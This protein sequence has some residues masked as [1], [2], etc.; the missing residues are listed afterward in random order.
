[1]GAELPSG[2]VTF[3]FTDIEG[4][5][6]LF[7][8]L[9]DSYP[10]LLERHNA[11][12]RDQ[13]N[14]HR[15]VE[16]K[17]E[18]DSF[19]VAFGSAADAFA[20]AVAAQRAVSM[21][22]WPSGA[23]VR[24]RIGIHTGAAYPRGNDYVALALH[25][26]ARVVGAAVGGQTLASA[27]AV[28]AAGRV[29]GVSVEP[30]GA[31]RL[32][33]FEGPAHLHQ[34]TGPGVGAPGAAVVRAV[35][36]DG[37][38]L[39]MP[40][41]S[42]VGREVELDD[43]RALLAPCRIVTIVAPGGMGKTRL[44]TEVGV[45]VA[46]AWGD[47]VW[48][49]ELAPLSDPQL[50]PV[51]IAHAV[52]VS[53]GGD[54]EWG[55]VIEH[56]RDRSALIILDN[57]EHLLAAAATAAQDLVTRCRG[58]GVLATSRELLGMRGEVVWRLPPLAVVTD[59]LTLFVNRARSTAPQ[60]DAAAFDETV[61]RDICAQLDG[62]PLAIELAA[63]RV[64]VLSLTEIRDGL[65]RRFNLLRTRDSTVPE[66]QRTMRGLLD[67]SVAL[68]ATHEKAALSRLAVFAGTFDVS[69]AA[70]AVAHSGIEVEDVDELVWSLADKSLVVVERAMGATRYRLLDTVRAYSTELLEKVEEADTTRLALARWFL[71]QYPFPGEG[72]PDRLAAL[73][74]ELES[75]VALIEPLLA[76]DHAEEAHFLAM[77]WADHQAHTR[78]HLRSTLALLRQVI[79]RSSRPTT[80]LARIHIFAS[81]LAGSTDE[82]NAARAHLREAD[83][84]V[85]LL[86][87]DDRWG[88]IPVSRGHARQ[89]RREG[90]PEALRRAVSLMEAE[91]AAAPDARDRADSMMLL[92][93]L[94]NEL[95]EDTGLA[96]LAEAVDAAREH[97][98]HGLLVAALSESAEMRLR[99]GDVRAAAGYQKQAL[100][101]GRE[102]GSEI[103]AAFS[104]IVAARI[105][106][107]RGDAVQ[108]V[109]LHGAADAILDE[110][111]FRLLPGDRALSDSMLDHARVTL[112]DE[113]F[114]R[115]TAAG[116]AMCIDDTIRL[117]DALLENAIDDLGGG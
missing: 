107:P 76:H 38:N 51:A 7:R 45:R 10:P 97:D 116:R 44:A 17:T 99:K 100:Q 75:V 37:H 19:L 82:A 49:V 46:P 8:R 40:L 94:L 102:L 26:A 115:Q 22:A 67:W 69:S 28:E 34:V 20:A 29:D 16:V 54:D 83:A 74:L 36:A 25:Q 55:A 87:G 15:G 48:M 59:S 78:G 50:V 77:L 63:A 57:C 43:I 81:A 24:V 89:A 61:V 113:L 47:G 114:D 27:D 73:S 31:F 71:D 95:G 56:L 58:V 91:L 42:F 21:E 92:A 14:R 111:G 110:V 52:G 6:R 53:A 85:D 112:G 109:Q 39:V 3:V 103:I 93:G 2:I 60:L 84:L 18:G 68:L 90:S 88:R 64:G 65:R 11:V 1:V 9:A 33:D 86:G 104:M 106:E 66:R 80:G 79:G 30:L 96:L 117:T 98:D 4:S 23:T 101:L 108:A 5:T 62:M 35:P 13:W 32:R 105:V 41:T 12:L 72:K 70:A